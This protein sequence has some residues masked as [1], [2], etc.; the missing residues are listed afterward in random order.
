MSANPISADQI[1]A[2][3]VIGNPEMVDPV[4]ARVIVVEALGGH[5][6][7]RSRTR[8]SL[9]EGKRTIAIGRGAL[10]DV[11]LD[12]EYVAVLHATLEVSEAGVITVTDL[13]TTNGILVA[14]KRHHGARNLVLHD[15]ELQ[16]GR[17]RLRVRTPGEALPPE[18]VDDDAAGGVL[19]HR[20]GLATAGAC[21]F[22]GMVAYNSWL[23]APRDTAS[24]VV[25][26]MSI[27]LAL[28]CGWVTAWALLARV[29]QGEWRW[30]RHAAIF[31]WICAA[32]FLLDGLLDVG[33]F[34]WS[35]PHW[36]YR[37]TL[38]EL[39][40]ISFALFWHLTNASGLARRRAAV[41]ACILPVVAVG[42]VEWVAARNRAR[43]VNH[44]AAAD[45][46]YPPAFRLR[47][48]V[49]VADFFSDAAQLKEGADQ[50]KKRLPRASDSDT[51]DDDN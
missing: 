30:A 33:W 11:I 8:I 12:D 22:V 31:F 1:S 38:I 42:A 16:V 29:L 20:T 19:H 50:K 6:R 26:A 44:I 37:S 34:A 45:Q 2:Q 5:D 10:A 41:V 14:G 18:R 48:A 47:G 7:V 51:A 17:T 43:D 36:P 40:A 35:L 3:P 23:D 15:D 21:L 24:A 28:A 46:I 9:P 13:G 4:S 25:I 27:T 32:Y 39:V 49:S